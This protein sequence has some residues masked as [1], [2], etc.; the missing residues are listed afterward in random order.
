MTYG[1]ASLITA[2]VVAAFAVGVMT[3]PTIRDN[4]SRMDAP[5]EA[6]AVQPAEKS[7]PA[8]VKADRPARAKAS[9]S[10]ADE[11]A[12]DVVAA[13]KAPNTISTIAVNLWEPEMRDRVKAVLNPGARP[14]TRLLTSTAPSSS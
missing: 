14:R 3:G 2:G 1:K 11:R 12:N 9:A 10:R 8:P 6:V 13:K 5:E 7:A 4:W